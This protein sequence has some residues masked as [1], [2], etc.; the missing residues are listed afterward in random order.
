MNTDEA[1]DT[2]RLLSDEADRI[3][4]RLDVPLPADVMALLRKLVEAGR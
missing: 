2:L 3:L 1:A 4:L